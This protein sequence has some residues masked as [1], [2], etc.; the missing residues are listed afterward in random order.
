MMIVKKYADDFP[1][2]EKYHYLDNAATSL[3]PR[4][5][6]EA[7]ND[8]Y[9]NYPANVHRGVYK[10]SEHATEK[11]ETTREKVSQMFGC[12]PEEV[13]F[14]RNTTE[15]INQ[16]ARTIARKKS[17]VLLTEMEH[18][19]NILPWMLTGAKIDYVKLDG[20]ELDYG[21]FE[22]KLELFR[23]DIFSFVYAS[24]VLGTIN[25]VNEL[26]SIC[27]DHGIIT[28]IDCAQS[29]P[30][31][32]IDFS[33]LGAD[34][35]AFS[36]HKMLGPTGIGILIGKMEH[37][38]NINCFF[39]GGSMIS[40][41]EK[42]SFTPAEVPQRFEAGTPNIAGVIGFGTAI[43]YLG[44][45]GFERIDSIE[46]QLLSYAL[47]RAEEYDF[48]TVH[49]NKNIDSSVGIFSFNI[50]GVHPHDVSA[51][52]DEKKVCIRAGHHCAQILHRS[53][54]IE[55]TARASFY[56]YNTQK[57]VDAFFEGIEYVKKVFSL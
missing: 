16:L 43:D 10:M 38:E 33:K 53:L 20:T 28:V 11:Y 7:M 19:S 39:G 2:L 56:F 35:V 24:N 42:H 22:S 4:Q 30:H 13:I 45:V 40:N 6:V 14:T 54:G 26:I 32:K 44:T 41:V 47:K 29:A 15:S 37:L 25:R 23:P 49:S 55:Y 5:V 9:Y 52:L 50:D 18:H 21:D 12:K 48:L 1:V 34:Y 17:K 51:L 27:K 31:I 8:Y 46:K 3:K 36:A 57:D